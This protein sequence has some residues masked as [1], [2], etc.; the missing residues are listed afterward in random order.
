MDDAQR[1]LLRLDHGE[2]WIHVSNDRDGRPLLV[3][4]PDGELEDVG[5]T[6]SVVVQNHRTMRVNV[7]EG[8]VLLR[9]AGHAPITLD[10][11]Q[12][13]SATNPT[14]MV[15]PSAPD[16]TVSVEPEAPEPRAPA[17]Y[18]SV[19][20]T[21]QDSP[22]SQPRLEPTPRDE[23]SQQFRT[24]V[25]TLNAGHHGRAAAEFQ[26]FV[27]RHPNDA[28]AEDAAYLRVLALHRSGDP[29]ATRTAAR[30]YLRAYPAGFR[31]AEVERLTD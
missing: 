4:L 18:K 5:T 22:S 24:A 12:S 20:S 3:K 10:A 19:A 6:F 8:R 15:A 1:E 16:P 2:L 17:S 25:A 7:E 9:L 28:R 14:Q 30:A 29:S 13:W 23:A 31:C 26:R 11:G 21:V 27:Q